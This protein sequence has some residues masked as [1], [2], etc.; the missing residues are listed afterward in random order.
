[1]YWQNIITRRGERLAGSKV[2]QSVLQ[3]FQETSIFKERE[4]KPPKQ[5]N[6]SERLIFEKRLTLAEQ[7]IL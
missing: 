2:A 5:T 4:R 7:M 1:M 6:R 3:L